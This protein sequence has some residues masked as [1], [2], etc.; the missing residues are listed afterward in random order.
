MYITLRAFICITS[1][2]PYGD[3]I[4]KDGYYLFSL[5]TEENMAQRGYK[6]QGYLIGKRVGIWCALLGNSAW[7]KKF[8]L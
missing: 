7:I 3:L 2:S 8:G 1:S 6:T 4:R 5:A